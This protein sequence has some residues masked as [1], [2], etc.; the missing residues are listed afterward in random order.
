MPSSVQFSRS[1]VSNSLQAHELQHAR[2]PRPSPT[3]GVHPNPCPSSQWCHPAISSSVIPF[4][5]CPQSFPASGSFPMSQL[6]TSGGAK[7]AYFQGYSTYFVLIELMINYICKAALWVGSHNAH[8]NVN[9]PHSFC[10]MIF[11]LSQYFLLFLPSFLPSFQ[12]F[13]FL[14]FRSFLLFSFFLSLIIPPPSFFPLTTTPYTPLSWLFSQGVLRRLW[15]QRGFLWHLWGDLRSSAACVGRALWI[16]GPFPSLKSE[17]YS[18]YHV[19]INTN[20]FQAG[21]FIACLLLLL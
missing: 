9:W 11:F 21:F 13:S 17:S 7:I 4:S 8:E 18:L 20:M 5:S 3:L 6:F 19:A 2:L 10:I 1:V 15:E 16:Y 14:P 12:S